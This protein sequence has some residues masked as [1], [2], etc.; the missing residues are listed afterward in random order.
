M[1]NFLDHLQLLSMWQIALVDNSHKKS[2]EDILSLILEILL[3]LYVVRFLGLRP[4]NF[5]RSSGSTCLET[6]IK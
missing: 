2:S 6:V 4:P 1:A 3:P 5:N